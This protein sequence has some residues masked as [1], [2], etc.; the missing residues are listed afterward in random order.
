MGT[1]I[2]IGGYSNNNNKGAKIVILGPNM[3]LSFKK[4]VVLNA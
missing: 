1:S 4:S 3:L 2:T